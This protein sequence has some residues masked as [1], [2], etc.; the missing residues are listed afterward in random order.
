MELEIL[1]L[2]TEIDTHISTEMTWCLSIA[3]VTIK[4]HS[5]SASAVLFAPPPV[6][7][8]TLFSPSPPHHH[9]LPPNNP[10]QSTLLPRGMEV[11]R[12]ERWHVIVRPTTASLPLAVPTSLQ[13]PWPTTWTRFGS[14]RT[15]SCSSLT[16]PSMPPT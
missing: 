4:L 6:S 9:H 2:A 10:P 8:M 11:A 3:V 16:S 7:R 15:Q 5:A 12:M 1:Y 14:Q 13:W